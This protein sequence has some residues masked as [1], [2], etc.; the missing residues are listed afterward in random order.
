MTQIENKE[1]EKLLREN[2]HL[3]KYVK[4]IEKKGGRPTF[5]SKVPRDLKEEPNPNIIY[6]TKGVVFIHIIKTKDMENAEYNA[7]TPILDE[8]TK[9]KQDQILELMFE[10]AHLKTDIKTQ[11][12][13]RKAIR[14]YL[15]KII[16][17]AS[18]INPIVNI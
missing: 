18:N 17:I 5:Y 2:P 1:V 6:A 14:D 9:E 12:D 16:I 11:D 8:K 3:D 7:I 10:K 15:N 4:E 13:L